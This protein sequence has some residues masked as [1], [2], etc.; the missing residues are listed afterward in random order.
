MH[1]FTVQ[2]KCA[3]VTACY[4]DDVDVDDDNNDAKLQKD[5]T[6]YMIPKQ[7]SLRM[8]IIVE[9]ER[10]KVCVCVCCAQKI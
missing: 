4:D 5:N 7:N 3:P 9:R 1:S 2:R 6:E 10:E 8:H